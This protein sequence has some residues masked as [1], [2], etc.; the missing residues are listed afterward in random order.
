MPYAGGLIDGQSAMG[1]LGNY[2][3]LT[4]VLAPEPWRLD[5]DAQLCIHRTEELG[6]SGGS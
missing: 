4:E 1:K 2:E 6:V 5:L 3:W